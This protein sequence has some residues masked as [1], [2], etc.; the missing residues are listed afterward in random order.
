VDWYVWRIVTHPKLRVTLAE[1]EKW[2]LD[3]LQ[4]AHDVADALEKA[5][6]ELSRLSK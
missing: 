3:D 4:D 5:E 2:S 6:A 1:L